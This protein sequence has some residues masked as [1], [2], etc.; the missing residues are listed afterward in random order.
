MNCDICRDF[1]EFSGST[2]KSHYIIL[3]AL[4]AFWYVC[5]Y[6]PCTSTKYHHSDVHIQAI[7]KD[8]LGHSAK[9]DDW[10]CW[11]SLLLPICVHIPYHFFIIWLKLDIPTLSHALLMQR[12][13][14]KLSCIYFQG[15]KMHTSRTI[16]SCAAAVY[17]T[18][19]YTTTRA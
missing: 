17:L 11:V 19:S 12:R 6:F 7:E 2:E 3:H 10:G 8:W 4:V 1:T 14:F 15:R 13:Y 9:R 16:Y 18:Y 5:S